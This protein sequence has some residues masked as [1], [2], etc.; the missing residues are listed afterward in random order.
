MWASAHPEIQET[1]FLRG[2][3]YLFHYGVFT[4][5]THP[6]RRGVKSLSPLKNLEPMFLKD[7]THRRQ[8]LV[9]VTLP[10]RTRVSLF[11]EVQ[12]SVEAIILLAEHK[13]YITLTT[14][15]I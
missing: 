3:R 4:S 7:F 12:M 9:S 6:A 13:H 15:A 11:V 10:C 5:G 1:D 8:Q 2:T 14:L